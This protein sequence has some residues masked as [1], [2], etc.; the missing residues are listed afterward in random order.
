[1]QIE[2]KFS[3]IRGICTVLVAE[4]HLDAHRYIKYIYK[5]QC[6]N[7]WDTAHMVIKDEMVY[8]YIHIEKTNKI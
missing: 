3:I 6:W 2:Q 1:M 4:I 7:F 8:L 5:H